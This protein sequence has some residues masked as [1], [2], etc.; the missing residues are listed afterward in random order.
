MLQTE[1]LSQLESCYKIMK[2]FN[3]LELLP[4]VHGE[5]MPFLLIDGHQ[6]SLDLLFLSCIK[7]DNHD[8]SQFEQAQWKVQI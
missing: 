2:E 1:V 7:D 3:N 5:V 8:R 4:R 6:S